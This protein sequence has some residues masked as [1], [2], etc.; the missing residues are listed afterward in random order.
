MTPGWIIAAVIGFLTCV[1]GAQAQCRQA[2]VIALDVSGSVDSAEYRLQLDGLASALRNGEVEHAFLA[3]TGNP[4]H[5]TVFEWS[6]PHYQRLLLNWTAITD[7]ATLFTASAHLAGL[8]RR[9]AP[10]GTALGNAMQFGA[11]LLAS[12]PDCWQRTL[13]ISGDGKSNFGPHPR[14]IRRSLSR[15]AITINA[16]VIGADAPVGGDT[17]QVEIAELS[18]YFSAWVISGGEAFVETAIGFEDYQNAMTRKLLRELDT[19]AVSSRQPRPGGMSP[20]TLP[21]PGHAPVFS[22]G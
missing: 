17:R 10:P 6:G 12:G 11:D 3:R 20:A 13:D 7:R 21:D 16:L 18:A 19:L 8:T 4:V 14:D 9:P 5:I 1:G 22:P 2:L 15:G